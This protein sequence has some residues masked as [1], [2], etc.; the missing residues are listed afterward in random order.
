[1]KIRWKT[2]W[3]P[4]LRFQLDAHTSYVMEP[5]GAGVVGVE[6]SNRIRGGY[7]TGRVR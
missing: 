1:M 6:L 2:R 4:G 7:E 3:Q 5:L